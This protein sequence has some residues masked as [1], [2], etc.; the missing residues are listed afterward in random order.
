MFFGSSIFEVLEDPES[1]FLRDAGGV[2]CVA[3]GVE[4]V[5]GGGSV[6]PIELD[7]S[8][9]NFHVLDQFGRL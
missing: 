5:N 4:E 1:A 7:G 6:P 9:L 2:T 3:E 8:N